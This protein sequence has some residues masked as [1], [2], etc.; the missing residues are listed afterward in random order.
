MNRQQVIDEIKE[1]LGKVPGF[2]QSLPDET[3]EHEWGLFKRFELEE[4]SIPNKYKQLMGITAAATLHCWYCAL[5]HKAMAEMEG[6]TE[7]EIQEANHLA[8]FTVG[9]S[10]YLNGMIY[11]KDKY[12]KELK[13]IGEYV[14]A[15]AA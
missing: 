4:T 15:H 1:T 3:L 11:D 8:K 9:W 10:T 12:Q 2:I 6:A 13:D 7:E 5:F 14:A